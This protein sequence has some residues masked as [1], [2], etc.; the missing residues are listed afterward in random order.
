MTFSRLA[1]VKIILKVNL[2]FCSYIFNNSENEYE[3]IYEYNRFESFDTFK[4]NGF[5]ISI[6]GW[7]A[8]YV[9]E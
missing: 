1:S 6:E 3:K 4:N 9:T 5:V 2:V 7:V 8:G